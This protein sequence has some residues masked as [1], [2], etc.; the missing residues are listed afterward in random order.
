M[1]KILYI[2]ISV[3]CIFVMSGCNESEGIRYDD[4]DI[5][6]Y[7]EFVNASFYEITL[8]DL[9]LYRVIEIDT[10]NNYFINQN[11]SNVEYYNVITVEIL[12]SYNDLLFDN[13]DNQK[14]FLENGVF[15]ENE[16][17]QYL[18]NNGKK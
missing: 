11:P 6:P 18:I 2:I 5:N 10:D 16:Q 1:K 12:K 7:R 13:F 9:Y 3:F 15:S 14:A 17:K 4:M 8:S